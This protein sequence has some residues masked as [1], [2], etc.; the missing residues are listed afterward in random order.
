MRIMEIKGYRV[1][2]VRK[3]AP[4]CKAY[5]RK[6]NAIYHA[7]F[8]IVEIRC[9]ICKRS[10][11]ARLSDLK[12]GT[13][14]MHHGCRN[15]TFNKL[16][17]CNANIEQAKKAISLLVLNKLRITKSRTNKATSIVTITSDELYNTM[18]NNCA[19][20]GSLPNLSYNSYKIKYHGLDR[21]DNNKGYE[22][23][24]IVAYCFICN[25]AKA[26]LPKQDFIA[27]IKRAYEHQ[28]S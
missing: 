10:K 19:Y 7:T 16:R 24:N 4:L 11:V 5:R 22:T 27:W 9:V 23:G 6:N 2:I 18:F 21:V 26:T 1:E 20:C 25:R 28:N 14:I 15:R 3:L 12:K 17:N 13:S 8:D